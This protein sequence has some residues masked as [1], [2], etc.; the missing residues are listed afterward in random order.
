MEL[1][2]VLGTLLAVGCVVLGQ[3]L[4]GGEVGQLVQGAAGVLVLGGTAGAVLLSFSWGEVRQALAAIPRVYSGR[5][6]DHA[7]LVEEL[8]AIATL[9]RKEGVLAVEAKREQI[10]DPLLK[11]SIK[12]VIDG[13]DP[14]TVEQIIDADIDRAFDREEAPARVFESA[15]GYAPT[16]GILGAVLGL[17]HVMMELSD[18]S[19][20]GQGIAVA[21]VSTLYGVGFANLILLPWASKLRRLAQRSLVGKELVKAGVLGIQ[22]GLNPYFLKEKLIVMSGEG[23]ER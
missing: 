17:I 1:S 12:F 13:F 2:A 7:P 5:A 8:V 22:A 6:S 20:I 21:F 15:G 3:M 19:K 11:K 4:D 18:P 14:D 9:A 23:K 16:I 10:A